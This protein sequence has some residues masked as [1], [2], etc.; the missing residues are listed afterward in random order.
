M[1]NC[2]VPIF[3]LC[4]ASYNYMATKDKLLH[5]YFS[6][7]SDKT[8]SEEQI[9][10]SLSL[11]KAIEEASSKGREIGMAFGSLDIRVFLDAC[12]QKLADEAMRLILDHSLFSMHLVG[13]K[14]LNNINEKTPGLR[15]KISLINT[16]YSRCSKDLVAEFM[17][18]H[19]HA[20]SE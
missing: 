6:C 4:S 15:V 18:T 3:A 8:V 11:Q 1:P 16:I 12:S 13:L 19:Y 2:A 10:N 17:N 20:T 14:S 5:E 9:Q 7:D